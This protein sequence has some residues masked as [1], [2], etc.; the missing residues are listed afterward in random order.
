MRTEDRLH[1]IAYGANNGPSIYVASRSGSAPGAFRPAEAAARD[2]RRSWRS[3][4]G[5]AE[6]G[7]MPEVV[8][9]QVLETGCHLRPTSGR[10][11]AVRGIVDRHSPLQALHGLMSTDIPLCRLMARLVR[12]PA[13]DRQLSGR[14]IGD[15]PPDRRPRCWCPAVGAPL[16]VP[17]ATRNLQ[18]PA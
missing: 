8:H 11:A 13:S 7:M 15:P 4:A 16:L 1:L 12:D 18:R 5:H 10:S 14:L 6:L 3:C 17:G 9:A 2:R